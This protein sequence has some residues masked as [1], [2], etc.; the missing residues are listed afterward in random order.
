M[1]S[2]KSIEHKGH[3]NSI[4]GNKINV[5]ILAMSGCASCHAKGVCTA[6][7]MQEKIVEVFD[8]TNQY[9]V[10]EEVNV[11]LKQ[12][13]GFRALFLGYVLPFILVLFFLLV[14]SAITKNEAISGI[15][16]LLVLVP[17]Y[18]ILYVSRNKI[19]KKFAFTINK[20]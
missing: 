10:G 3:I 15:G 12:S 16:A 20:I 19:R 18:I 6:S 14:L 1:A 13:L 9:Q 8:F 5:N 4:D 17:Y 7:D 2:S 11:V